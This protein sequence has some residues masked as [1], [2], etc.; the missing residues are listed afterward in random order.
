[1]RN[2]KKSRKLM[3]HETDTTMRMLDLITDFDQVD[4][5]IHM[6]VLPVCQARVYSGRRLGWEFLEQRA[7]GVAV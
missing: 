1:M 4:A 6:E 5:Q 2:R 3:A 7:V